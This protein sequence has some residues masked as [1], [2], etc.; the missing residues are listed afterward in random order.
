MKHLLGAVLSMASLAA[1]PLSAET[2]LLTPA[3]VWTGEG[4]S[5]PNWVVLVRDG[6]IAAVGPAA[7]VTAPADARGIDLPGAT[8]TPGLIE[9]HSHLFLHPYNEASWNDQVLKEPEAYRTLQ[10]AKFA[11][12]TLRAGFTTLRD[13]GTEGAGFADV[14]LK[15]AIDDGSVAGPRLFVS[16]RAIVATSSYGPGP[17]GFRPDAD[18]PGGAQEVSGVDE[19]T[20][21]V[22]EQAGRGADWIKFYADYR[23]G[24]E[25]SAQPAFTA[26]EMKAIVEAAHVGGRPV[27]A[28][29][30]TDAG[31]RMA[32][33]A[34]VD[35]IEHGYGGSAQTFKLMRDRHV[36]YL[37]TLTAVEATE[38]YFN[39][40]VPGQSAPTPKIEESLKAFHTAMAQGVT[41]G[42]GS[43]VGVFRHGDNWR[44]PALMVKAGMTPV[45][46]MRACTSTA[47]MILKQ[48]DRIGRIAI[49]LRG[50]LA[51][52]E[53][54]PTANIE[55][56]RRPVFVA[57]DG[58]PYREPRSAP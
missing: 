29:A 32:V 19:A 27:A 4:V 18:L 26:N 1:M 42:C 48:Q 55:D 6:A 2:L 40:Y 46:A 21:A 23:V 56:L 22:R 5:H 30:A 28:H 15:R 49:G 35:T 17:R 52:F 8:L 10:A 58:V 14:S 34:G 3:R 38:T 39:H 11:G 25:G 7:S 12:D 13:L 36:A 41:I 33:D 45:D 24:P 16:T 57:K 43:D 44:E 50:D 31:M 20:R 53:G 9:L 47:A 51:A 54:D 37:P